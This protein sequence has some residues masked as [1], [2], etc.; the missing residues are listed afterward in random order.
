MSLPRKSPPPAHCLFKG[1]HA[2]VHARAPLIQHLPSRTTLTPEEEEAERHRKDQW[3]LDQG[4]SAAGRYRDRGVATPCAAT[5]SPHGPGQRVWAWRTQW[6]AR[7]ASAFANQLH[8]RWLRAVHCSTRAC[9]Q[10]RCR[11]TGAGR[12][13]LHLAPLANCHRLHSRACA[14]QSARQSACALACATPL[15]RLL[16]VDGIADLGVRA[17]PS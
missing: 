3:A 7:C 4:V 6:G 12:A 5:R 2:C 14:Y 11:A 9:I 8:Q 1:L 16:E 15:A 13:W 10:R 17:L